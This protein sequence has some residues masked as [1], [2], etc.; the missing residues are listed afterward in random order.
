MMATQAHSTPPTTAHQYPLFSE[1]I[2]VL[3]LGMFW[4]LL[5]SMFL[6]VLFSFFFWCVWLG[7]CQPSCLKWTLSMFVCGRLMPSTLERRVLQLWGRLQCGHHH[8]TLSAILEAAKASASARTRQCEKAPTSYS[9]S[10]N[11]VSQGQQ[12]GFSVLLH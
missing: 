1:D 4:I 12:W 10:Q 6:S 11:A 8:A 9:P 7:C 5:A 2:P 3:T